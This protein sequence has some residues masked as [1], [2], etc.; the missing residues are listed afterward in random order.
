MRKG[1]GEAQAEGKPLKKRRRAYI[2]PVLGS[3][4]IT[5]IRLP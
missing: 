5:E 1:G 3:P 2:L 4:R